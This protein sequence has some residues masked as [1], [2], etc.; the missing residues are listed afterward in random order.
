MDENSK[1]RLLKEEMEKIHNLEK[2][3]KEIEKLQKQEL[4]NEIKVKHDTEH[5]KAKKSV[6][7]GEPVTAMK[8]FLLKS[9][10]IIIG[11]FIAL[12]IL[13][14]ILIPTKTI[15]SIEQV[16]YAE[17]EPYY[18]IE[19]A[20]AKENNTITE[21]VKFRFE[22]RAQ[23]V[24]TESAIKEEHVV[25]EI[26]IKNFEDETGCWE[27]DYIVYL[28]DDVHDQG[29]IKDMC[30]KANDAKIFTT[31]LYIISKV[32]EKMEYS[33]E[34]SPS[35]I[36]TR[37]MSVTT[38]ENVLKLTNVT[39]YKNVTKYRNETKNKTVNWLFGFSIF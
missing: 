32:E 37:N 24:V 2:E 29:T 39:K 12:V 30:V 8:E 11:V 13:G 14:I 17:L 4:K 36:P 1:E 21:E 10:F 19:E 26:T 16:E 22:T 5:E 27:Y 38:N 23:I 31:P 6:T 25:W 7:H 9:K 28:D 18:V 35:K 34:I 20:W 33:A 3:V 15:E